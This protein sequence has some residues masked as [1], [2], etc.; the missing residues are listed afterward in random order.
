MAEQ[1]VGEHHRAACTEHSI[2][3]VVWL[4]CCIPQACPP[5]SS[6]STTTSRLLGLHPEVSAHNTAAQGHRLLEAAPALVNPLQLSTGLVPNAQP[7][8]SSAAAECCLYLSQPQHLA[9]LP[10]TWHCRAQQ[11]TGSCGSYLCR[12]AAAAAS[13]RGLRIH[14]RALCRSLSVGPALALP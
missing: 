11:H 1:R 6:T 2:S 10:H 5:G 8:Q 3:K 4:S 14:T 7:T 9:S 12:S 13:S